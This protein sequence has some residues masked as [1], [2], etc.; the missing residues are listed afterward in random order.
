MS[1]LAAGGGTTVVAASGTGSDVLALVQSGTLV[2]IPGLGKPYGHSP[3]VGRDGRL[4]FT[5]RDPESAPPGFVVQHFDPSTMT[6]TTVFRSKEPPSGASWGPNA[7][8]AFLA[9]T[10]GADPHLLVFDNPSSAPRRLATVP[11]EAVSVFWAPSGEFVIGLVGKSG[12]P[13]RAHILDK[14]GQRV[15][16]LPF[17][18]QPVGLTPDG[19]LIVVRHDNRL[20]GAVRSPHF[21]SVQ[22]FGRAPTEIWQVAF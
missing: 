20:L 10:A 5:Q 11:R 2:P 13:G 4:V 18:W 14:R 15:G 21:D 19:A 6:T 7:A 17:P 22:E 1:W 8:F 9:G 3:A 12:T 16:D